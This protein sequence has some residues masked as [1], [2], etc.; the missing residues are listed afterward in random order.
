MVNRNGEDREERFRRLYQ[1]H[2]R[3]MV[4]YYVRAFRLS[5]PDAEELAQEAFLRFYE[6]MDEY[7]GDAEWAFFQTIATRLAL[8]RIRSHSTL[9]RNAPTVDIDDPNVREQPVARVEPDYAER[10]EYAARKRLL[11][12]EIARLSPAQRQCMQAWLAGFTYQEI[13]RGLRISLDA[14][15]SRLRDARRT[16]HARLGDD[17]GLPE[18]E[19]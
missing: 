2:Y 18:D 12:Q 6:A 4:K 15:K 9:K 11:H 10:E 13:A 3:R 17:H 19:R 16:L 8:N 1:K 14:V 7:R 5:E